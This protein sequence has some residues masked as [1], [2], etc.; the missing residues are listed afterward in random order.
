MVK[1]GLTQEIIGEIPEMAAV[2]SLVLM[3]NDVPSRFVDF[4][5]NLR[6][7]IRQHFNPDESNV[8]LRY[9]MASC[10]TKLLYYEL[11]P[12]GITEG[13]RNKAHEWATLN[14]SQKT[15]IR[16]EKSRERISNLL[17]HHYQR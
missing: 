9:L 13:T 15:L 17:L 1:I 6:E 16:D 8:D 14:N 3:E 12:D 7:S 11:E 4:T 2:Y 5:D 10:K